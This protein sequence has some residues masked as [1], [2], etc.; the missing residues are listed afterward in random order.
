VRNGHCSCGDP[1]CK[2]PGK[3]P[4][5]PHG[6]RDATTAAAIIDGWWRRWPDANIGIA[7]GQVSGIVVLD[8]DDLEALKDLEAL[9]GPLP[10]TA[11][12][13]TGRGQHYYFRCPS[14]ALRS[15]SVL[16]GVELRA[17]GAY[18]VA[19]PSQHWSGRQYAWDVAPNEAELADLPVWLFESPAHEER[20]RLG[21]LPSAVRQGERNT[22]LFR[23]AAAFRRY[24]LTEDELT[25]VLAVLNA[26]RCQPPLDER[27]LRGIA[28]S[29]A[30]YPAGDPP[31]LPT[32]RRRRIIRLE[33]GDA[34]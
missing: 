22:L 20:Q 18:V 5:T 29:A 6:V 15:R 2:S 3:H 7:T 34:Q 13:T 32:R 1:V 24:G 23:Y 14:N 4:R 9:H 17:D 28:R 19:P 12:A 21:D 10:E 25:A 31:V 26:S 11:S 27:E 33:V 16:P 30:R 8:V